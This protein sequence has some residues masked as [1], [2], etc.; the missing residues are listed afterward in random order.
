MGGGGMLGER[1][2]ISGLPTGAPDTT[3]AQRSL[4]NG[5]ESQEW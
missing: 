4:G 5:S 1:H 3:G 2:A